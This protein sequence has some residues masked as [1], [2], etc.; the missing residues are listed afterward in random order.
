LPERAA[1]EVDRVEAASPE[2]AA[3]QDRTREQAVDD[4]GPQA[5]ENQMSPEAH[6]LA[7]WPAISAGMMTADVIWNAR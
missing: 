1:C 3:G 6:S 4:E 2:D 7:E 5:D